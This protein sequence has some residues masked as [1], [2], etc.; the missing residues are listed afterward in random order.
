MAK[1]FTYTVKSEPK[2]IL[3]K[4][5]E[6]LKEHPDVPLEGNEETGRL[7]KRFKGFEGSYKLTKIETGT[8]VEITIDRRHPLAPWGLIKSKMDAE[9][10]KW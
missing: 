9:A 8:K 1:T 4:L 2:A 6:M 3:E 5:K 7:T 10:K